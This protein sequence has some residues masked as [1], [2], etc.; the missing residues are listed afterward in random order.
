MKLKQFTLTFSL[1][2]CASSFLLAAQASDKDTPS[3]K[4]N[5]AQAE[6]TRFIISAEIRERGVYSHGYKQ[7]LALD[8]QGSFFV[9]QRTRLNFDFQKGPLGFFVQIEDGRI[10]GETNGSHSQ[11]LGVS[12]AYFHMDIGKGFGFKIGRMPLQYEDGRYLSYS[13][14]DECPKTHDALV[15]N[16]RSQDKKTKV[17][18]GASFSN[19]S[20][21]YFLNPYG[22][23]NY[24]KYLLIGYISHQFTP[25]FR[26]GLLSVTDF[27]EEKSWDSE[28]GD[29]T[30][31]PDK[32]YGRSTVGLYLERFKGSPVSTL[33]YG[34]GQFGKLNTGQHVTSGLASFKMKYNALPKLEL[35]LGYDFVSGD[36][37][38]EDFENKRGF[39]KFLGS[40]HSFL[41]IMDFFN[42]G[43]TTSCL[44]GLHQPLL[45][46]IYKPAPKHSLELTGRYFWTVK[47]L[48]F[49]ARA[50]D[51]LLGGKNNFRSNNLGFEG[52]LIYK[53]KIRPDLSLEAG[54]ALH[55]PTDSFEIMN[56]IMPGNSKFAH[57][58]YIMISYKP[59]LFNLSKHMKRHN[60]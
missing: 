5:H 27:Q 7:L 34:Y 30:Y 36:W 12:Q 10:W 8:Q 43:S 17:D 19:T 52:S 35:Q 22:L 51:P 56:E 53:Y 14:W 26:L 45:S 23:D 38:A 18:L 46:I 9:G 31:N 54:Y 58:G 49:S 39:S 2:L 28:T 40:T 29:Y 1:C 11:G 55:T 37:M 60:D 15:F 16:F 32:I 41:G 24:F 13:S 47:S 42:P 6:D 44:A 33:I 4:E 25:D 21:S 20:D 48:E 59:T 3:A 50:E 57:F